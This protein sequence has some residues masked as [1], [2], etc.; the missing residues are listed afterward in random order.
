LKRLGINILLVLYALF[1]TCS[2]RLLCAD[3]SPSKHKTTNEPQKTE[4]P[5]EFSDGVVSALL[6]GPR[7]KLL[8]EIETLKGV[9]EDPK[10]ESALTSL[11]FKAA[12]KKIKELR[13]LAEQFK[14]A[15]ETDQAEQLQRVATEL[16]DL[17]EAKKEN[18]EVWAFFGPD[19][20]ASKLLKSLHQKILTIEGSCPSTL[21]PKSAVQKN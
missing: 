13:A 2:A 18:K 7:D 4:L 14:Q 6:E 11:A 1:A 5:V 12:E 21:L 3:E 20:K 10:A 16:E 15:G 19:R 17:S 9:L 8:K